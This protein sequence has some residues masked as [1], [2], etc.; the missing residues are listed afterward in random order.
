M[1]SL[2]TAKPVELC[3]ALDITPIDTPL[4]LLY[5][6][7]PLLPFARAIIE[8]TAGIVTS[9]KVDPRYYMA[10]GAAGVV[11]LERIM[12]LIPTNATCIWDARAQVTTAQ[13]ARLWIQILRQ[14]GAHAITLGH[15]P[16]TELSAPFLETRPTT[17]FT[18]DGTDSPAL[19]IIGADGAVGQ[20]FTAVA[21]EA[22]ARHRFVSVGRQILYA[23]KRA[24]FAEAAGAAARQWREKIQAL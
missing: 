11:A 16:S 22:P 13:D 9:Y 4:P 10:E 1:S 5:E 7:E 12:R 23:S 6:D 2:P 19:S 21:Q 8:A 14:F 15:V 20:R 18:P 24:D 17:V 3:L